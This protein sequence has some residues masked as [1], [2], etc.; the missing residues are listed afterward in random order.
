MRYIGIQD[1]FGYHNSQ[2][3]CTLMHGGLMGKT[4]FQMKVY[5]AF[6]LEI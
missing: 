1:H 5:P 6:N 2:P 3:L 4:G